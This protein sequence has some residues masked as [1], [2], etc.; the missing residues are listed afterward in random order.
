MRIIMFKE[1][2][3]LQRIRISRNRF[4]VRKFILDECKKKKLLKEIE[5]LF[6]N[7]TRLETYIKSKIYLFHYSF[8]VMFYINI[9]VKNIFIQN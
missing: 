8:T 9:C 6:K 1:E 5:S 4:E 2:K 7:H 3:L